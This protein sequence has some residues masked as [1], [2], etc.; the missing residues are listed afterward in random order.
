VI[1]GRRSPSKTVSCLVRRHRID[2]CEWSEKYLGLTSPL[3]GFD[4][5]GRGFRG[6]NQLFCRPCVY[7]GTGRKSATSLISR[8]AREKMRHPPCSFCTFLFLVAID[9]TFTFL[10]SDR[11]TSRCHVCFEAKFFPGIRKI[12]AMVDHIHRWEGADD[13]ELST[14]ATYLLTTR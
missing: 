13:A 9:S 11:R 10:V 6:P 2:S 12:S 4:G 7:V 3:D 5:S 1:K 8:S 14:H